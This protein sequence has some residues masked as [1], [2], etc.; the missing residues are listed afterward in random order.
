M[1]RTRA[2]TLC[3]ILL[4]SLSAGCRDFPELELSEAEFD[5][6]TPYP[7]F[8][9]VEELLKEPEPSIT[10]ETQNALTSRRD[11]LLDT[12]DG[13]GV[14]RKDPLL[15]RLDALRAKR[16]AR[17]TGDPVIDDQLRKRMTEG[18]TV[19]IAPE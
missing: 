11:A 9:P 15:D 18:V 1:P 14:S 16:D 5:S 19:P 3:F 10:D 4:A 13:D 8:V 17:V 7:K 6:S 12:P 2:L